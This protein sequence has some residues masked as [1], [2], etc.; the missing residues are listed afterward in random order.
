MVVNIGDLQS[1]PLEELQAKY[2]SQLCIPRRPPSDTYSTKEG[3]E[4]LENRS[5][6]EW[7]RNIASLQEVNF[8]F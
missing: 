4:E 2:G 6:L 1:Q 8:L 7:R 5:F 3:L